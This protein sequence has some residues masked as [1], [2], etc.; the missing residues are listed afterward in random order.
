MPDVSR[1]RGLAEIP[2]EHR[3]V[4]GE[5]IRTRGIVEACRLSGIGRAAMLSVVA[6]GAA[7]RGTV[8]LVREYMARRTAA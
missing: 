6:Q 4:L 5:L 2:P 1:H 3:E 8:A 7:S